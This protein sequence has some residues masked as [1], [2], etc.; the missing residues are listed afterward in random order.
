VGG[1]PW[2]AQRYAIDWV[3]YRIVSGAARTWSGPEDRNT[4]Y[5][6]YDAPIQSVADGIVVEAMD[7]IAE[8]TP[9]SGTYA[10]DINFVNAGGNH[11]VV[12]IGGDRYAFYAHM[13]PGSVRVKIG[14]R[15]KTGQVLGRVGNTGSSTEPHLHMHIVDR[16]SFLAANGV[17]DE[18]AAF[19]ASRS[20][21]LIEKP[22][23]ELFFTNFTALKRFYADYPENNAAVDFP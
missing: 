1:K 20:T 14:E 9:H 8:N 22:N 17:P 6:C 15:V 2:L 12:D 11:V 23:D 19:N 10:M 4:S 16:P 3:R 5:F 13:R 21:T 18:I 7:G